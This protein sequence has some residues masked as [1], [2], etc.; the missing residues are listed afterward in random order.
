M[1]FETVDVVKLCKNYIEKVLKCAFAN[2]CQRILSVVLI[3]PRNVT[4]S[5]YVLYIFM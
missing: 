5:K 1:H 3:T 4:N 2:G